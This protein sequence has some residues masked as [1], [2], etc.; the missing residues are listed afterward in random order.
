MFEAKIVNSLQKVFCKAECDAPAIKRL[1]GARGE[2]VSFQ[3]ACYSTENPT[4]MPSLKSRLAPFIRVREVGLVPCVMPAMPDDDFVLSSE[5]GLYPDPLL[6][7][8]H[9]V[10]IVRRNW[11][12]LWVSVNIP[13]NFEPG[14]YE[15]E[16][17]LDADKSNGVIWSDF[18]GLPCRLNLTL[19]VLPFALP[20][21][22]LI[23]SNWFHTDC[24]CNHYQFEPWSD[25]CWAMLEKYFINMSQHGN[26]ILYT[27]LWTPPLDTKEGGERPTNQLLDITFLN[28]VY[29]FDFTNLE[30]WIELAR[31]CGIERFE[32]VHPFTQWGAYFTPKIMV[33]ENGELKRKF[34]WD[35]TSDSEEY[36]LFIRSL[37]PK[38]TA[39]LKSRGLAG[40]CYFHIS[41]EPVLEHLES[42][43]KASELIRSVLDAK[44]FPIIDAMSHVEFFREGLL[45]CPVPT[46]NSVNDFINE[47]VRERWVYYCGNWSDHVPNRQF[48]MP[49]MRNRVLG[50]LL[51]VYRMDGFLN[52]AYNFWFSQHS[53]RQDIDPYKEPEA[54]RAFCGGG[55]FQVYPGKDGPVDS[56]HYEVY[57]EA[58]QDLR[59][60]DLLSDKIGYESV[61]DM[62]QE[63]V[64]YQI[65]ISHYPHANSWL[66]GLRERVNQK[67]VALEQA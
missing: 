29:S 26:N 66:L 39:F 47:P 67:L 4:F 44:D 9:P 28:G 11:I 6:P 51:F 60:L 12:A 42:Y 35:V 8:T 48:G 14:E 38:L 10:R 52:W 50:V 41:D 57:R 55:S 21:Q 15:I 17:V 54:G 33:W 58:L 65:D 53:N 2:T 62:I 18:S 5:P 64:G 63:G 36:R 23:S 59:A 24:I 1:S 27:P 56:I 40:K 32:M 30:R 31:K 34:G 61:I 20:E 13:S 22:R 25:E 16:I 7:I 19:E 46:T 49:S 45:D 3:I 43:H 37:F